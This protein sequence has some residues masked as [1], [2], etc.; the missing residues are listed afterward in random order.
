MSPSA[1]NSKSHVN[2]KDT[3][4]TKMMSRG[5][6]AISEKGFPNRSTDTSQE[7]AQCRGNFGNKSS[8]LQSVLVSLL[9][10]NPRGLSLKVG[11]LASWKFSNSTLL[12]HGLIL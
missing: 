6:A 9:M 4:P 10:E 12:S 5:N 3:S 11:E 7:A 1:N 8:D 2:G